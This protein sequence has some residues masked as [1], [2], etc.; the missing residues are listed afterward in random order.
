MK[1][2]YSE[3]DNGIRLI[4]LVGS[5]DSAGFN[6]IDLEFT[7]HCSGDNARILVDLSEVDFIASVG[8]RMLTINAKS[9]ASRNGKLALFSPIADVKKY[10]KWL[11][12]H[13]SFPCMTILNQRKRWYWLTHFFI[14]SN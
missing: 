6:S 4:K 7:S 12:F 13:P 10:W 5:L 8:I 14:A 9:L 1:L 11:A 3:M 2:H